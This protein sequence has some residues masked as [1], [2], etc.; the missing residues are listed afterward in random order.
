[1]RGIWRRIKKVEPIFRGKKII[2]IRL[3]NISFRDSILL[4]NQL[5]AKLPQAYGFDNI[6]KK[7]Y[8]PFYLNDGNNLDYCGDFPSKDLFTKER[9]DEKFDIW[10]ENEQRKYKPI[11]EKSYSL[12]DELITYC[13]NDVWVLTFA[14]YKFRQSFELMTGLDPLY[15]RFTIASCAMYIYR[16]KFLNE[17][18]E[19]GI[20][21]PTGY[22][23]NRASVAASAWLDMQEKKLLHEKVV[24]VENYIFYLMVMMNQTMR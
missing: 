13:E 14:L 18:E 4:F 1:M 12:K 20:T 9:R 17:E 11:G 23:N 7:G 5:L 22:V 19:I 16:A 15:K 24:T 8:S 10:Y 6:V 21:P 3:G 2:F